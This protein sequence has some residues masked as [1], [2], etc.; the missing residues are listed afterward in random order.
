MNSK[1]RVQHL[2]SS[3]LVFKYKI[4]SSSEQEVGPDIS[5]PFKFKPFSMCKSES[6]V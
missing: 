3:E 5:L 2:R 4:N 1:R 6:G